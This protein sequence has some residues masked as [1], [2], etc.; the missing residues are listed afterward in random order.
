[1]CL[2]T[3]VFAAPGLA[4]AGIL[5]DQPVWHDEAPCA[6]IVFGVAWMCE[7][8]VEFSF[9]VDRI[10]N[11]TRY[12]N[13]VSPGE[14]AVCEMAMQDGGSTRLVGMVARWLRAGAILFQ[15]H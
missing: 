10:C 2:M 9:R 6:G 1:M 14:W 5:T 4:A 12:R 11:D 15:R 3:P 13:S 8:E 7:G